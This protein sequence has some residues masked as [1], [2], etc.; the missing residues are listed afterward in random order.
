MSQA[1]TTEATARYPDI[2]IYLKFN[3]AAL[4]TP[5]LK[6]HLEDVSTPDIQRKGARWSVSHQGKHFRV[7]WVSNAVGQWS[8]LWFNSDQTPWAT[9]QEAAQAA[10]K[11]LNQTVRC[12]LGPWQPGDDP[13]AWLEVTPQGEIRQIQWPEHNT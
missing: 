1:H 3:D 5:F 13:D 10:A 8:S 12:S 4:L 11:E 9:D 6:A 7:Q 2:E